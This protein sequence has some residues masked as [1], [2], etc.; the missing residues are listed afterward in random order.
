MCKSS[1]P[2]ALH[3]ALVAPQEITPE[4]LAALSARPTT[5]VVEG[6]DGEDEEEPDLG[7]GASSSGDEGSEA[8]GGAAAQGAEEAPG[9]SD[10]AAAAGAEGSGGGSS[11]AA[12]GGAGEENDGEGGQGPGAGGEEEEEEAAG[13][14]ATLGLGLGWQRL[15]VLRWYGLSLGSSVWWGVPVGQ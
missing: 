11:G 3:A 8:A 10:A 14:R 15:G 4:A 12:A 5:D 7:S 6:S 13:G 2:H 1:T 9:C